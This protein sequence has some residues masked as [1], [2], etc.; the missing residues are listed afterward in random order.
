MMDLGEGLR[1]AIARLTN[2]TIIDAKTIREF[3]KDLQKT[4]LSSDVEVQLV[5]S[6]TEKIEE[7]ALKS[8]PPKGV[9]QRDYITNIVYEEL[10]ALMGNAYVPELKP[11]KILLAGLY[12]SGKTTTA[13][14]LAKFYQ[15]RGLSAGVIC[16][17]VSR[18]A[19]YQQL[20]TLAKQANVAFFGMEGERS[21]AK[22]AKEGLKSLK[23]KKVIICDTSGRSALDGALIEELKEVKKA[24]DPDEKMLVISA[25]MGQVA[26][27]QAR[28]FG[29]AIGIT[30]VILTKSDGS[31][32]GGGALSAASA[33]NA[34]VMFLGTGEKLADI[35]PFDPTK[36][37]ENLLGVPDIAALTET[38]RKAVEETG[39]KQEE[40][41]SEELNF[42]TFYSQLKAMGK[43]GPLKNL[44]GMIGAADVPKD[45]IE[46]GEERLK[47]FH[48]IISSMTIE[49]RKNERLLHESGRI[50]RIARGS[51][52]SEKDVRE[53]ISEFNKMKK[54]FNTFKNDRSFK[55]RFGGMTQ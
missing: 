7:R 38:V 37:V 13:A 54:L 51:G 12:G 14:K 43:M 40:V 3:N 28:E 15:D 46:H 20:E 6:L 5:F 18:P 2:A 24:F 29:N 22:I 47:R 21:A 35:K 1:K 8:K 27:K 26:G 44:F 49:E 52:T 39:L 42:D 53:M 45:M 32:K 23:D 34:K 10:V 30:G 33:A 50:A 11:K 17:D 48:S 19:A 36:Y 25:D 4:M 41:E 31:A 9:S 55:K 16:C